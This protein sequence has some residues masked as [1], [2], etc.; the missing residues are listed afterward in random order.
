MPSPSPYNKKSAMN[1]PTFKRWQKAKGNTS[2]KYKGIK[3][4]KGE[5]DVEK[6]L[7]ETLI[8]ANNSS[9]QQNSKLRAKKLEDLKTNHHLQAQDNILP[10]QNGF[11]PYQSEDDL[12]GKVYAL[13]RRKCL[14]CRPALSGRGG[15]G[16]YG[17]LTLG[18]MSIVIN[19]M[20]EHTDLNSTSIFLDVGSGLGKPTI[21]VAQ[22]ADCVSIGVESIPIRHYVAMNCM[23]CVFDLAE[24]NNKIKSAFHFICSDILAFQNLNPF[25]HVYIF[26]IG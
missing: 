22:A 6:H 21:H 20:K 24:S 2:I 4:K 3:F 8:A 18:S 14:D 5:P 13:I 19:K 12:V 9:K 25:T 11:S 23:K 15:Y 26:S 17:E 7:I 1:L 10:T 16:V